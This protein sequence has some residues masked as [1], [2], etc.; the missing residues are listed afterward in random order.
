VS[1]ADKTIDGNPPYESFVEV[2]DRVAAIL[3]AVGDRAVTI[4]QAAQEAAERTRQEA[5][6]EAATI[7]S[8]A[9]KAAAAQMKLLRTEIKRVNSERP[10]RAVSSRRVRALQSRVPARG[11]R[12][13]A[14]KAEA[15][16]PRRR[17]AA[18]EAAPIEDG[19]GQRQVVLKEATGALEERLRAALHGL[20]Q[21]STDL[22]GILADEEHGDEVEGKT[23]TH[24][25]S[26]RRPAGDLGRLAYVA[27]LYSKA[28][29]I[30]SAPNVAVAPELVCTPAHVRALVSQARR[31]KLLSETTPGRPGGELTELGRRWLDRYLS[32]YSKG[33]T[34][35]PQR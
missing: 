23:E 10:T 34:K 29:L 2:G 3:Q 17:A 4:L 22:E 13:E 8:R 20:Q 18:A 9:E 7:L 6:A 14:E 12:W 16:A 35:E 5:Q 15:Q 28:C 21:L 19:A 33:S 32:S 30:S 31:S 11:K 26:G 24:V 27:D 1:D 25:A